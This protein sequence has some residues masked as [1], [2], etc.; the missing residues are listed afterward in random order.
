MSRMRRHAGCGQV[1]D[2]LL[3]LYCKR[4]G[5]RLDLP[6]GACDCP[7]CIRVR[8][9]R[10]IMVDAM[11]T[12]VSRLADERVRVREE[13]RQAEI[14][15]RPP[16]RSVGRPLGSKDGGPRVPRGTGKKAMAK[17]ARL[18]AARRDNYRERLR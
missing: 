18:E 17:R 4:C 3:Q 7:A 11:T 1:N 6:R 16:V 5:H 13:E 12:P 2:E 10:R 14:D 9:E 8:E 15:A